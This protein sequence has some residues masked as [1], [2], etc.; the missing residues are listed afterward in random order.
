MANALKYLFLAAALSACGLAFAQQP[1]ANGNRRIVDFEA[2]IMRSIRLAN[3]STALNLIGSVVFYHNGAVI[4]CDSAVRYSDKRMECFRNVVINKNKTYVYGDRADYNGEINTA[5]VYAPIIKMVDQEAVMYTYHFSFNTLSNVGTFSGGA[6]ISD[7]DNLLESQRGYYNTKTREMTCVERVEIRNPDYKIQSD[8]LSYNLDTEIATFYV[9]TYIWNS[10]GEIL[11][12]NSGK[13]YRAEE[14]YDFWSDAYILTKEQEMWADSIRYNS[15]TE[16]AIARRNIQ[17]RDEDNK[18]MSFGDLGQYWGGD[19]RALL[20]QR[21]S[22]MSFDPKE[23]TLYM[24]ADSMFL[25]TVSRFAATQV[26]SLAQ[27]LEFEEELITETPLALPHEK[28]ADSLAAPAADSVGLHRET[29]VEVIASTPIERTGTEIAQEIDTQSP[30]KL[31]PAEQKRIRQEKKQLERAAKE[32]EKRRERAAKEAAKA[33]KE[34]LSVPHNDR[35]DAPPVEHVDSTAVAA[36]SITVHLPE[37]AS[38]TPHAEAMPEVLPPPGVEMAEVIAAGARAEADSLIVAPAGEQDSMVRILRGYHNVRIFRNDFQAVCD[39]MVAFSIDST[40]HLYVEPVLWN[41]QNQIAS[42]IIDVYTR[43]QQL[44]RALFTGEPI[45]SSKV[46]SVRFNQVKGKVIEAFFHDSEIYRTDVNGNGQTYYYMQ[47]DDTHEVTGFLT[48]ECGEITFMMEDRA[49][50]TIT[51]RASPVYTIYPPTKIPPDQPVILPGFV[52]KEERRPALEDVFD[53]QIRPSQR[54]AYEAMPQP[55]FPTTESI[56][57]HKERLIRDGFWRERND[58]ISPQT[59]E[60]IHG[61]GYG[62]R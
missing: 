45:M 1:A 36:D 32:D 29:D 39:S 25:Y 11:S 31:S 35:H 54:A 46:D 42:E 16:D 22:I 8:S 55:L 34:N 51:Y 27:L 15:A 50:T 13:Y 18:V 43:N 52:W 23:D 47:D 48:A 21:P 26:D 37:P 6:T 4:T 41:E 33:A 40:I 59:Q 60:F 7:K 56:L 28:A 2:D 30:V 9:K 61:L 3:D 24:R 62:V 17:V 12:A 20:T 58:V 5:R 53:R 44:E 19:E 38:T 49:I 14:V 57:A 10:K